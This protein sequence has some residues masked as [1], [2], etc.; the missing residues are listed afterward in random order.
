M[1]K[2]LLLASLLFS[3]LVAVLVFSERA[4]S[5]TFQSCVSGESQSKSNSTTEKEPPRFLVN[6][7]RYI[8]CSGTFLD[9]HGNGITAL[10][11]IVIAAFTGTLWRSTS[12]QALLTKEAFISDKRAFVFTSGLQHYW[13]IDGTGAYNWRFRPI[14]KNSGNTQTKRLRLYTE[15]ELRDSPLPLGFDFTTTRYQWGT[16][17]SAPQTTYVGG[18]APPYT[19]SAITP[20]DI[21]DVQQGRKYLYL[22][23]WASYFDVFPNTPEHI[24]RFC[25]SIAPVGDP[26][27]YVP[28]S[29]G[30]D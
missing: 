15:C 24:T 13:E 29:S 26:F 10:A 8:Q 2:Q 6:V 20:Q 1:L 16:G 18:I 7:S 25:W 23:G 4:F 12:L 14:W 22:W 17:F 21:I 28:L 27:T 3:A 11:T 9:Q 5:P 30:A 19:L